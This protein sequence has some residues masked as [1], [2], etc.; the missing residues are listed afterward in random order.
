MGKGFHGGKKQ[1]FLDSFSITSIDLWHT[2]L[3]F[4][5][6]VSFSI[7]ITR[8]KQGAD[9]STRALTGNERPSFTSLRPCLCQENSTSTNIT[10]WNWPTAWLDWLGQMALHTSL[11]GQGF[12]K[13]TSTTKRSGR[14]KRNKKRVENSKRDGRGTDWDKPTTP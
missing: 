10:A 3:S 13:I 8:R 9:N 2:P 6:Y 5:L 1:G 4:S 7:I 14:I 12:W 11:E